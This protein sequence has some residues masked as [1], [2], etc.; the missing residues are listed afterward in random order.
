[1]CSR[2]EA[3]VYVADQKKGT[4]AD[5]KNKTGGDDDFLFRQFLSL[6]FIRQTAFSHLND[7]NSIRW[8]STKLADTRARLYRK[9]ISRKEPRRWGDTIC[10]IAGKSRI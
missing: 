2:D 8:A 9:I 5:F 7:D 3:I 4:K 1:M 10:F 6:G